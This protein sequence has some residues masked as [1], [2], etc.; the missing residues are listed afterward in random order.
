[1]LQGKGV[2]TNTELRDGDHSS[3]RVLTKVL[4]TRDAKSF[5]KAHPVQNTFTLRNWEG[6]T[7]L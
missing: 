4:M 5:H 2:R 3:L 6:E 7:F 1:M